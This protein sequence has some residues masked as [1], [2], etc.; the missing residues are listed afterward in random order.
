M[1]LNRHKDKRQV[2][3]PQVEK[4]VVKDTEDKKET[5]KRK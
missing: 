1:L 5:K 4:P 2:V 3:N